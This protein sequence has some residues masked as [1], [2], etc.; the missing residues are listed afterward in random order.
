MNAQTTHHDQSDEGEPPSTAS[1]PTPD[2]P[3]RPLHLVDPAACKG[4]GVCVEV[5][6]EE[7]L[8]IIN[9]RAATVMSRAAA[10]LRCG[11]CVAV[12]PTEALQMPEL[13]AETFLPLARMPFGA[14]AFLDFLRLRRSVRVFKDRP[15][16]PELIER[17]LTAAATAPMGFPPHSTGV[18]IIKQRAELDLLLS[19]LVKGYDQLLR[20]FGNPLGR[21]LVRLAAGAEEYLAL[22][23]R[24]LDVARHANEA[25]RRDGS[26]RYLYRAP[27]LMVF[28][29]QRRAVSYVEN[30]HLVCH[31]TMLAALA[32]GL[33]S[34]II[35]MIPPVLDRSAPLRRRWGIPKENKVISAL[36]LGHPKYR[37]QRGILRELAGVRR[38]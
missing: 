25:Y 6:P 12:C 20:V 26:D 7:V 5:C 24:I 34:T 1:E 30:A 8:E 22:K 2:A 15:V 31:H 33:G 9:G 13:P 17:L 27:L 10:C 28:H 36:I 38:V 29:G 32:L 16:E 23:D 37:Y 35:G 19:E 14:D 11:Q 3:P 18:I 21:A 4:E